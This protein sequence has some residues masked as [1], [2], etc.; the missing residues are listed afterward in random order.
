MKLRSLSELDLYEIAR[1]NAVILT[2]NVA[3]AM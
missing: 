2:A 3:E 1:G